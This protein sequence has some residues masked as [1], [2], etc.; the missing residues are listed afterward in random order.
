MGAAGGGGGTGGAGACDGWAGPRVRGG[1]G[2]L[3]LELK[4]AGLAGGGAGGRGLVGLKPGRGG[5]GTDGLGGLGAAAVGGRCAGGRGDGVEPGGGGGG[6]A[7]GIDLPGAGVPLVERSFGRP[8]A[9]MSPIPAGGPLG[10]RGGRACM[11]GGDPPPEGVVPDVFPATV[12]A[13]LSFVCT[14]F[15]VLP[16]LIASCSAAS[17]VYS[18]TKCASRARSIRSRVMAMVARLWL[19]S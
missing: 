8:A 1:G 4:L 7:V 6:R 2:G 11:G 14:F 5:T 12:G 13:D 9:K 17:M 19:G 10:G 18:V 16:F 3:G 15:S